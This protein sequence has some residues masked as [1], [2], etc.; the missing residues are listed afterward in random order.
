MEVNAPPS[1]SGAL[2]G[3]RREPLGRTSVLLLASAS[4]GLVT[5]ALTPRPA[6]AGEAR[7]GGE[8]AFNVLYPR[9][10]RAR[11]PVAADAIGLI[12]L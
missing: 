11:R 6:D 3:C 12:R 4:D 2:G 8:G 5:L 10:S 1:A 9:T 7:G